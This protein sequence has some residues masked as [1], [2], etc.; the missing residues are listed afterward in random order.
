M[1]ETEWIEVTDWAMIRRGE[2]VRATREQ[3]SAWFVVES[4]DGVQKRIESWLHSYY[5]T[6]GWKVTVERPIFVMPTEFGYYSDS[7]GDMWRLSSYGW[8]CI[9]DNKLQN[10]TAV[11]Y[12]PF[13][14]LRL[15]TEV[16]TETVLSIVR[17]L[18][19]GYG[20]LLPEPLAVSFNLALTV[21]SNKLGVDL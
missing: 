9:I 20:E 15:E 1:S 18:R 21:A 2:K 7:D 8:Q 13:E 19:T 5:E 3:D 14:R 4:V 12:A 11:H 6:D 10:L 16:V 17:S